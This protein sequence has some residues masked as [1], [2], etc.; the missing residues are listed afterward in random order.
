M[1]SPCSAALRAIPAWTM[2]HSRA[3]PSIESPR[4]NGA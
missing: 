1:G 3:S 4:M 2:P